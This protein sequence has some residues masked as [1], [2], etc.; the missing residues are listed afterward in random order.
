MT[1]TGGA[2]Y[3]RSRRPCGDRWASQGGFFSLSYALDVAKRDSPARVWPFIAEVEAPTLMRAN[4]AQREAMLAAF[5]LPFR[6]GERKPWCI[7]RGKR[8]RGV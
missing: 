4:E 2:P 7:G 5:Y 1:G 3:I 8:G 6:I